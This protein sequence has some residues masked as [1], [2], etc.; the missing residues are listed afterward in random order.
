M[1]HYQKPDWFTGNIFNRAVQGLTEW[2]RNIRVSGEGE[3][4][5]GGRTQRFKAHE[6]ADDDK[7][8][9]LRAY[10]KRWKFEVGQF[11]GGVGADA[12]GQELRWIAPDHPAF[13]V[14]PL[15]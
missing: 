13:L 11:F 10:L 4:L 3:L 14:E 2:V 7:V 12:S 1:V 6:I 8:A 9:L 15:S 5:L